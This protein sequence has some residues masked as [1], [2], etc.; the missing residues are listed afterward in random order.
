MERIARLAAAAFVLTG[1]FIHLQLWQDGYRAIPVIG[2]WFIAN[3]VVSVLLVVALL[4]RGNVPVA[5]ASVVFSIASLAALVMSRTVG[6]FGFTERAWTD[7]S[8]QASA[9]ELGAIVALAVLVVAFRRPPAGM[10]PLPVKV[11]G[12]RRR[13]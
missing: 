5:A 4:T 1:G 10:V 6:L 3:A 9:A 12:R 2:P 8:V 7:A 11:D 13:G